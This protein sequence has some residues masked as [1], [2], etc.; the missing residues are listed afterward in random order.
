MQILSSDHAVIA[1]GDLF[2]ALITMIF[3]SLY[4]FV[5]I[6]SLKGYPCRHHSQPECVYCLY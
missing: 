2:N 4:V 3:T 5:G 6:H 1:T